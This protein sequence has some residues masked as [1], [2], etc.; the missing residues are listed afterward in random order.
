MATF[1][2]ERP[3]AESLTLCPATV[4]AGAVREGQQRLLALWFI[5][6][7]ATKMASKVALCP[8]LAACFSRVWGDTAG[9]EDGQA[10]CLAWSILTEV[11]HTL[12]AAFPM[13]PRGSSIAP[14]WRRNDKECENTLKVWYE[15]GM[16]TSTVLSW[17]CF[18]KTSPKEDSV[19]RRT[20]E[21]QR[22]LSASYNLAG[23]M[24]QGTK[25]KSQNCILTWPPLLIAVNI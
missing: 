14:Q 17:V 13:L 12:L 3:L 23:W 9:R 16:C 2:T 11:P 19:S 22:K 5:F 4:G 6:Q 1:P 15:V 25:P 8:E 18:W 7:T 10:S 24:G 20:A 21:S